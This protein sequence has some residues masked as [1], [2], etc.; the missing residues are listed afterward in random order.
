MPGGS[1]LTRLRYKLTKLSTERPHRLSIICEI[2]LTCPLAQCLGLACALGDEGHTDAQSDYVCDDDPCSDGAIDAMNETQLKCADGEKFFWEVSDDALER[3]GSSLEMAVPT[4][5]GT[6]CF[7]C[8]SGQ[9]GESC[10]LQN[11]DP[12]SN[13]NSLF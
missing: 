3:T 9:Y 6:Y 1:K 5:V 13:P 2:A 4:L 11:D 10:I 7:G 12:T 8:P